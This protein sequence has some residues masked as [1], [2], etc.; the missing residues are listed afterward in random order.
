RTEE[1]DADDPYAAYQ[2]PDD[3]MW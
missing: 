1:P 3:L 2:V